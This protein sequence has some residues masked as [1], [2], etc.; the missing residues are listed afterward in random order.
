MEVEN[1]SP[2]QDQHYLSKRAKWQDRANQGGKVKENEVGSTLYDYFSTEEGKN[3][4]VMAQPKFFDQ[5]YLEVDYATNASNYQKPSG[6]IKGATW[7]DTD[8]QEF[9][10]YTE[11]LREKR[12]ECGIKPDLMIRNKV[13]GKMHFVE[14]KN[15]GDHGNAHERCGKYATGILDH[16]KR[17]MGVSHHPISYIFGGD[18]VHKRKYDLELKACYGNFAPGH[19]VLLKNETGK[20]GDIILNWFNTVVEPLIR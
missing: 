12:S 11:T 7:W 5:L 14:V 2:Q 18:M 10:E 17:K 3:Y 19:L 13:N 15:Q 4:E 8:K 9:R 6:K 16:M 20:N 1:Q